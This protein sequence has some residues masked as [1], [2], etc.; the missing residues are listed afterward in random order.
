MIFFYIKLCGTPFHLIIVLNKFTI[1]TLAV[2]IISEWTISLRWEYWY[3]TFDKCLLIQHN[4]W[5]CIYEGCSE[6]IETSSSTV[7]KI[8]YSD[9][10]KKKTRI[11]FINAK[12]FLSKTS[13]YHPIKADRLAKANGLK[14]PQT[15][16]TF[17]TCFFLL[18]CFKR[19]TNVNIN[20]F[21]FLFLIF[22]FHFKVPTSTLYPHR[23]CCEKNEFF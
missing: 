21:F 20:C 14:K 19:L 11:P 12:M 5:I 4:K 16:R 9:L 8:N 3:Q 10:T 2:I 17:F 22:R 23:F 6:I 7:K 1:Y 13:V 18:L 15:H